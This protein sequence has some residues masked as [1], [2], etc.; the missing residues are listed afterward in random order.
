MAYETTFFNKWEKMLS[1]WD[2]KKWL[3]SASG[4]VWSDVVI[5]Q[6]YVSFDLLG[7]ICEGQHQYWEGARE[8]GNDSV[9]RDGEVA[10]WQGM[11][12]TVVKK[13][14]GPKCKERVNSN[15]TDKHSVTTGVHS[16]C[17]FFKR[18]QF[19]KMFLSFRHFEWLERNSKL[20]A[21]YAILYKTMAGPCMHW[22]SGNFGA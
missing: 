10:P 20:S 22:L 11:S 17:S 4:L 21:A 19:I 3:N 9:S 13:F 7:R 1:S 15:Q 6:A 16:Q 18:L 12:C 2:R 14:K 8:L 5:L